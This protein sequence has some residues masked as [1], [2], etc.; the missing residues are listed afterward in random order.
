MTIHSGQEEGEDMERG[1][2]QQFEQ[3]II[4]TEQT[5]AALQNTKNGKAPGNDHLKVEMLKV[6]VEADLLLL[7]DV[8]EKA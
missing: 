8:Y 7:H 4:P 3:G 1:E 2:E 5:L 6:M